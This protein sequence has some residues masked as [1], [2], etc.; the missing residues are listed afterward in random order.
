MKS[1]IICI[2]REFCKCN[3]WSDVWTSSK[4]DCKDQ[5]FYSWT[6]QGL[7]ICSKCHRQENI[8][9]SDDWESLFDWLFCRNGKVFLPFPWHQLFLCNWLHWTECFDKIKQFLSQNLTYFKNILFSLSKTVHDKDQSIIK[10]E[11]ILSCIEKQSLFAL[12][13]F[14]KKINNFVYNC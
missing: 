10:S 12:V 4:F 11:T 14:Y 7:S 13:L 1:L 6:G 2:D 8:S 9:D 3:R 5:S